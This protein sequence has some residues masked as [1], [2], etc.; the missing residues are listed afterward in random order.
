M[1]SKKTGMYVEIVSSTFATSAPDM[2]SACYIPLN[3]VSHMHGEMK[4]S[5]QA[6]A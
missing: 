6:G 2:P 5:E 1:R 4:Y 3:T